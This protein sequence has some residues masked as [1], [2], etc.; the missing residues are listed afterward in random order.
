MSQAKLIADQALKLL[1]ERDH[2]TRG[3]VIALQSTM[4]RWSG[5]LAGAADAS[6]QAMSISRAGQDRRVAVTALAIH[7]A[8][9]YTLGER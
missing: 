3:F 9:Q 2:A 5:D 6:A 1:P 8:L 7:G 4:L